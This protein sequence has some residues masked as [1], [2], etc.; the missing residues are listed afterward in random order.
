LASE[1]E[2]PWVI[3]QRYFQYAGIVSKWLNI[4]MFSHFDTIPACDRHTAMANI[5]LA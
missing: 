1:N 3:V 5:M 2:G 4:E